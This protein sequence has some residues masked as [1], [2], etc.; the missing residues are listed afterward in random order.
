MD[1]QPEHDRARF[2]HLANLVAGC[3]DY[4]L[5]PIETDYVG[6]VVTELWSRPRRSDLAASPDR[7]IATTRS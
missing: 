2:R 7:I 1:G 3:F 6:K 4:C 5:E